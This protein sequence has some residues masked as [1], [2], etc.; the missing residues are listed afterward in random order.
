MDDLV[1]HY[2]EE[3]LRQVEQSLH[4]IIRSLCT[5]LTTLDD[6]ERYT[7]NTLRGIVTVLEQDQSD[8]SYG[9]AWLLLLTQQACVPVTVW[10]ELD[11]PVAMMAALTQHS[12]VPV[13]YKTKDVL[14]ASAFL[15]IG[16]MIIKQPSERVWKMAT[17]ICEHV[18][19]VLVDITYTTYVN[20]YNGVIKWKAR[21]AVKEA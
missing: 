11:S 17:M 18:T 1:K 19:P 6:N 21:Y 3:R 12:P 2:R 14:D 9:I 15:Q 10:S 20:F 7:Q 16:S 13:R 4:A 5:Y 8:E